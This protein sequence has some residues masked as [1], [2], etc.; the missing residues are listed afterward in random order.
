MFGKKSLKQRHQVDGNL[1]DISCIRTRV[2]YVTEIRIHFVLRVK[3][4]F[5]QRTDILEYYDD[6]AD[7]RNFCFQKNKA[8]TVA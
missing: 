4:M 6:A 3:W 1:L 5:E 2:G 7:E 8:K